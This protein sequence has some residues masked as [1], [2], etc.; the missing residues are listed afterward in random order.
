MSLRSLQERLQE[1]YE[2]D[3]GHCIEDFLITDPDLARSL[4]TSRRP[5]ETPE[6]LLVRQ[7]GD[8]LHVSLY[9][10]AGV[11]G[12]VPPTRHEKPSNLDMAR[13]CIALEGVSHFLFLVWNAQQGRAVTAMEMELQG[14]VDKFI[15]V[16][17]GNGMR[18]IAEVH[19]W[20]FSAY[21]LRPEL[22]LEERDRYR[23]ANNYAAKYCRWLSQEF[24]HRQRHREMVNEL[25]RFYRRARGDKLQR[26]IALQ[27]A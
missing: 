11:L 18:N 14:E 5:R 20:L 10:D 27:S 7:C 15:T 23:D 12:S 22:D 21:Q 16:T 8:D 6:K 24:L 25:R 1:L 3:P 17:T 4:D 9:L 19:R 13:Y 2:I 26:I